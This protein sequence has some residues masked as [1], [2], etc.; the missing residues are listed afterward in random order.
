MPYA[1]NPEGVLYG[2]GV[3]PDTTIVLSGPITV[4][5]GD[6]IFAMFDWG[7]SSASAES[8]TSVTDNLGNTYAKVGATVRPGPGDPVNSETWVARNASA[9]ACVITGT[10]PVSRDARGLMAMSISGLSAAATIAVSSATVPNSSAAAN[11]CAGAAVTPLAQPALVLSVAWSAGTSSVVGTG[12]A[13]APGFNTPH[14]GNIQERVE[15]QRVTSLTPIAATYTS[16]A[17]DVFS[18]VIHTFVLQELGGPPPLSRRRGYYGYLASFALSAVVGAIVGATWGHFDATTR[19]TTLGSGMDALGRPTLAMHASARPIFVRNGGSDANDGLTNATAK[20]T[21]NA[22]QLAMRSGFGDW[23]LVAAG[24]TF[25]GGLGNIGLRS[26]LSAIYPSVITTYDVTDPLNVAKYR[27]GRFYWGANLGAGS[28]LDSSSAQAMQWFY[29]ENGYSAVPET[30]LALGQTLPQAAGIFGGGVGFADNNWMFYNWSFAGVGFSVQGDFGTGLYPQYEFTCNTTTNSAVLTNI[31]LTGGSPPAVGR[32]VNGSG[33]LTGIPFD[34]TIL[35]YDS[36]ARTLTLDQ[37]C[38]ATRTG[39]KATSDMIRYHFK[40]IVFRRVFFGRTGDIAL[41]A[42]ATKGLVIEDC[43]FDRGGYVGNIRNRL[44]DIAMSAN[45]V[46]GAGTGTFTF[47]VAGSITMTA[48]GTTVN[49]SST[50]S[51]LSLLT[52]DTDYVAYD[53]VTGPGVP[54]STSVP[55]FRR[56]FTANFRKHNGYFATHTPD[57]IFRRTLSSRA[58]LTGLQ[59]RGGGLAADNAFIRNPIGFQP[60]GGDYYW[61]SE[62]YGVN[63]TGGHNVICGSADVDA[64]VVRSYAMIS[65][66]NIKPSMSQDKNLICNYGGAAGGLYNRVAVLVYQAKTPSAFNMS[67][68]IV[69]GWP[70]AQGLTLAQNEADPSYVVGDDVLSLVL[71]NNI[72]DGDTTWNSFAGSSG[73][74]ANPVGAYPDPTRNEETWA[75]SLGYASFDAYMD[76]AKDNLEVDHALNFNAYMRAGFG[77]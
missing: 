52:G 70:N 22:G 24:Q 8:L 39:I 21:I 17:T 47:S 4:A 26:G 31:V 18:T 28:S 6:T 60:G 63:C 14:Y 41:Y 40:N 77:R 43:V 30:T 29:A 9:G 11:A 16:A 65:A 53:N 75:I 74:L 37:N 45:A 7:N 19:A 20:A 56:Q 34:C 25:N 49:G 5:A 35:A 13:L 23:V 42:G 54:G 12:F 36:V 15:H 69:Y 55:S 72:C 33:P 32:H 67:N 76:W 71:L 61:L 3:A 48:T 38:T 62:P 46:A 58:S 44:P 66:G 2:G 27:L 51:N 73:N 57:S 68:S 59:Q 10:L 1:F 64:F 50:I